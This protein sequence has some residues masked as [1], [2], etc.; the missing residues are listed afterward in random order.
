VAEGEGF[1]E[2][3]NRASRLLDRKRLN[4]RKLGDAQP[5]PPKKPKLTCPG[6]GSS[7]VWKAGLRYPRGNEGHSIQRYLCRSCGF[8]FSESTALPS[9]HRRKRSLGSKKNVNIFGLYLKPNTTGYKA[10]GLTLSRQVCV[11]EREAENLA[12]EETRQKQPTREGTKPD[13][14]TIKGLLVK[15]IYWL[16]KENYYKDSVYPNLLHTLAK[17]GANLFDPEDVKTRIAKQPWKDGV[18]RLAVYAYD[19]MTKMLNIE[20][21]KPKYKPG[22]TLPFVPDETELDQLIAATQSRRLAAY[23]QTLKETFADPGEI[24]GLEWID[25]DS[26]HNIVTINHPVK[27][28]NAGQATVSTKLIAMLNALPKT[29]ERVFP[30]TYNSIYLSF[31]RVRKRAARQMQNPRLLK[32]RFTTFRHWGGTM[33]AYYTHGNVLKVKEL[34]RH[35]SIQNTM[36]YIHMVHFKDPEEFEVASATTAEEVKQ[37]AAAGFEKVDEIHGIHVFRRP[38]RFRKC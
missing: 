14:E 5:H 26:K 20:W 21:T 38:K 9:T 28:H 16:E 4:N 25:I 24:L 22:D 7:R 13:K 10:N 31:T 6:C 32:I 30:T 15:Y 27:G 23:L 17:S 12:R 11:S 37:L 3:D 18:K 35:K 29:S 8:R 19:A 1:H 2:D 34:L 33:L 36:K